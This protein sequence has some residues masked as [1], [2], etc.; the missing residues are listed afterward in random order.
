[1]A[2]NTL[3]VS[4]IS[5]GQYHLPGNIKQGNKDEFFLLS[6]GLIT[7]RNTSGPVILLYANLAPSLKEIWGTLLHS[8]IPN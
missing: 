5:R 3:E 6:R 1:V 2:C 4:G 7:L 8:S